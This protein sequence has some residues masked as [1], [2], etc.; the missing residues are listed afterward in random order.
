M[1]RA[2]ATGEALADHFGVLVDQ[3]AHLT[4]PRSL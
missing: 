1:E 3:D 2:V 4:P